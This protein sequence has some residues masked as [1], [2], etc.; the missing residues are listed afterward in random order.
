MGKLRNFLSRFTEKLSAAIQVQQRGGYMKKNKLSLIVGLLGVFVLAGTAFGQNIQTNTTATTMGSTQF[1]F[2]VDQEFVE[3]IME[4][5]T[6]AAGNLSCDTRS[7]GVMTCSST[8]SDAANP[9]STDFVRLDGLPGS[10]TDSARPGVINGM[11]GTGPGRTGVALVNFACGPNGGNADNCPNLHTNSVAFTGPDS[12]NRDF[13]GTLVNSVS[14]GTGATTAPNGFSSFTLSED[15]A[16]PGLFL[17]SIDQFID[18]TVSLGGTQNMVFR[19]RDATIGT[20]LSGDLA[21]ASQTDATAAAVIPSFVTNPDRGVMN[22]GSAPRTGPGN[23]TFFFLQCEPINMT[24]R[25]SIDQDGAADPQGNFGGMNL[26]VQVRFIGNTD[27][28][29]PGNSSQPDSGDFLT[30]GLNTGINPN[31]ASGF[32]TEWNGQAFP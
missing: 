24:S 3:I 30:P 29:I 15:G 25:V 2:D 11:T 28:P 31:A 27:S 8:G 19:Q 13:I 23:C 20:D 4:L 17:G 1:G 6:A 10:F 26:D 18:S 5:D 32:G 14:F 7:G 16:N 9:D 21:S 22:V 12:L